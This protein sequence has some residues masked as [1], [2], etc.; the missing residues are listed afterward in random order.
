MAWPALCQCN[1]NMLLVFHNSNLI[2]LWKKMQCYEWLSVLTA[3]SINQ[4][5]HF[6]HLVFCDCY[7]K[8]ITSLV[9]GFPIWNI[10]VAAITKKPYFTYLF[11]TMK[12][13]M[14]WW[15]LCGHTCGQMVAANTHKSTIAAS[16]CLLSIFTCSALENWTIH[17]YAIHSIRY[18]HAMWLN[19]TAP[20]RGTQQAFSLLLV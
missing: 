1:W 4:W 20:E 12:L 18:S 6:E 15:R 9:T 5:S 19:S 2:W 14:K 13:N 10:L 17:E 16:V 7:I 8:M 3:H 11:E